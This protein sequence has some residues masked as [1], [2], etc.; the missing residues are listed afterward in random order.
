[1]AAVGSATKSKTGISFM[2]QMALADA[3]ARLVQSLSDPK[4]GGNQ[5]AASTPAS[6]STVITKIASE[7]LEGTKIIKRTFGPKGTL[8]VLI[9]IDE[10]GAQKLR[11]TVRLKA[12]ADE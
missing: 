5:D 6:E 4:V 7:T 10:A 1:M 2:E 9:G 12:G 8:Y 11:E 3:R